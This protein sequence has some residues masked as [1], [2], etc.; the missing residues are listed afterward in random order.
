[1]NKKLFV[2]TVTALIIA[3]GM[4]Q[5]VM[6]K[7]KKVKYLGHNYK[8]EV[9][10]QKVPAGKGTMNVNGLIIEGVFD[11]HSATDAVVERTAYLGTPNTTFKGMIT[12]D[13]S[14]NIVLKAGG[15]LSTKYYF[16]VRKNSRSLENK[17]PDYIRETL[18]E[19]RIINSNNFETKELQLPLLFDREI[20]RQSKVLS[21]LNYLRELKI[22]N[23]E[24]NYSVGLTHITYYKGQNVNMDVFV[25]YKDHE[26]DDITIDNYK[27][28]E[29]RIWNYNRRCSSS[30]IE[31]EMISVYYPDG[32]NLSISYEAKGYSGL[33]SWEWEI[34]NPNGKKVKA[35]KRSENAI[36]LLD[37]GKVQIKSNFDLDKFY[38]IF[39]QRKEDAFSFDV[40]AGTYH[41]DNLNRYFDACVVSN[42]IDLTKST[43][44]EIEKL[45]SEEV[46]PYTKFDDGILVCDKSELGFY[47]NG[48]YTTIQQFKEEEEKNKNQI[49]EA[50][51]AK[52]RAVYNAI[53]K[54]YG[55]KYADAYMNDEIIV[56]MPEDLVKKFAHR[57]KSQSAVSKVYY[58]LP[59][60]GAP[61][62]KRV[63]TVYVTNGKVTSFTNHR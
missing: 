9:N 62:I 39:R 3:L 55:K 35:S 52:E 44:V 40:S 7:E 26:K 29:S 28:S 1:M 10:D 15:I 57:I 24:A 50:E 6:A 5:S 34:H 46:V 20:E 14:E 21:D 33:Y 58:M 4:S 17:E 8:G 16:S 37:L 54:K 13:E 32:S 60:S 42:S 43:N 45:L 19:D 25:A 63:K 51:N 36:M 22:P 61:D 11:A 53:V 47:R 27:D 59:Y 2:L 56:G 12:Y 48:K 49:K 30:G 23:L 41:S 18:K 31:A 38:R